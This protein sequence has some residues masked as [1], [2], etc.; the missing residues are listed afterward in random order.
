MWWWILGATLLVLGALAVYVALGLRLWRS[1]K[2]LLQELA[3]TSER[4]AE[5]SVALDRS[6][7]PRT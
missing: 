2:A 6:P 4:L 5:V 1:A 3:T 7:G